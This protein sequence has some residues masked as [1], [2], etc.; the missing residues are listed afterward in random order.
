MAADVFIPAAIV[1]DA[2]AQLA[3]DVEARHKVS[4]VD[5]VADGMLF[6]LRDIEERITRAVRAAAPLTAAQF[7]ARN[8]VSEQAITR[9]C[10]AGEIPGAYR[11]EGGWVIPADAKRARGPVVREKAA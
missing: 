10:R 5:P 9:W 3:R 8:G 1:R 6:V 7:A 4:R 11:G 2:L